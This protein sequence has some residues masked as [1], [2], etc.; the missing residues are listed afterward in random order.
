MV[1]R[2]FKVLFLCTGNSSRSILAESILNQLGRERF[3]AYSAGYFPSG[4]VNSFALE[5]LERMRFPTTGLCS[6]SVEEFAAPDAPRLD[7]V[8]TVCD[9]AADG[10]RTA[11]PG[12]P[13]IAHWGVDYPA[14]ADGANEATRYAILAAFRVLRRRV[15][16]FAGLPIDRL[17]ALPLRRRLSAIGQIV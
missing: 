14:A 2:V 5:L 8:F 11:W 17:C 10:M 3:H 7:F 9:E 4:S 1:E 16:L 12:Q 13:M 15:D 6:K